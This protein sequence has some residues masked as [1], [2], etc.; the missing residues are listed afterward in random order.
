MLIDVHAHFFTEFSGRSDWQ[1]LNS[2]RLQAGA[3]IG[4]TVHVASILGSWGA[5]SPVYFPSP[6]DVAR[7]NDALIE[8]M[9]D[10]PEIRGY[11]V[12]NPNFIEHAMS[13][14]A[15]RID[16]GM[17]GI[18]L[19]ASRR[20]DDFLLDPIARLA[21]QRSVPIL[22]HVWHHR[23]RDWPGQEASDAMELAHLAERH[24][25]TRFILAHLGGGG[26]W[27]HSLRVVRETPNVWI[28]LSGSGID[29]DMLDRA[30]DL[31]GAS[32][33]LWGSDITMDTAWG[34]LRYLEASGATPA[35]LDLIRCGN[36]RQVFPGGAFQ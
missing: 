22:H 23:R 9:Q 12:V 36:A 11:C 5:R 15:R 16:Q 3:R 4:I 2:A 1:T 18:K 21:G 32:R 8:L 14:I 19:A 30:F 29:V 34:K 13:E 27:A 20:A 6:D 24:P 33:L 35:E 26:D 28:D 10:H 25:E 17:I 7:A 31:L